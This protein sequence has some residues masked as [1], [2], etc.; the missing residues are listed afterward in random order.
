[1][2]DVATI[3]L[4]QPTEGRGKGGALSGIAVS[5]DTLTVRGST[6]RACI[7]WAYHVSEFQVQGPDWMNG[8]RTDRYEILAKASGPVPEAQLRLM[9]QTLLASRFQLTLHHDTKTLPAYVLT[10]GKGGIK[11]HESQAAGEPSLV[12]DQKT[13]TA[14]V[15]NAPVSMLVDMLSNALRAPVLDMTGL[16]G[17]YDVTIEL[18]KYAASIQAGGGAPPDVEGLITDALQQEF[19]LKLESKKAPLDLLIVDRANKAPTDN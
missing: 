19:G 13:L 8:E 14:V 2:F 9:L 12:P 6:L 16:T 5:P 7:A 18:A 4:I 1:V 15:K 3:R 11:A 10:V 17:R